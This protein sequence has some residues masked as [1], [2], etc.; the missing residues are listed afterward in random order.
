[1]IKLYRAGNLQ[2]PIANFDILLAEAYPLTHVQEG[3]TAPRARE[4]GIVSQELTVLIGVI[5]G[6]AIQT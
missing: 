3:N 4:V 6:L 5:A 1:M 2:I